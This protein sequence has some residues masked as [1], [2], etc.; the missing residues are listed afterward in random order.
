MTTLQEVSQALFEKS[1]GLEYQVLE[2]T[3][4]ANVALVLLNA[5]ALRIVKNMA[6]T[7]SASEASSKEEFQ[8]FVKQISENFLETA[9]MLTEQDWSQEYAEWMEQEKASSGDTVH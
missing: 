3:G 1:V 7:L 6:I 5:T 4:D 8:K 9:V 2:E